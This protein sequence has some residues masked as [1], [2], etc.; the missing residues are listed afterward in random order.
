MVTFENP[1]EESE[2]SNEEKIGKLT[3]KLKDLYG[4]KLE[5]YIFI[6]GALDHDEE[7]KEMFFDE[8]HIPEDFSKRFIEQHEKEVEYSDVLKKMYESL[9]V[10]K[11]TAEAYQMVS[12]ALND[13]YVKERFE[14]DLYFPKRERNLFLHLEFLFNEDPSIL[15]HE[16]LPRLKGVKTKNMFNLLRFNIFDTNCEKSSKEDD[17]ENEDLFKEYLIFCEKCIEQLSRFGNMRENNGVFTF[18]KIED[19]KEILFQITIKLLIT[20]FDL[21][22][23]RYLDIEII[24]EELE[25][26]EIIENG[27]KLIEY[28]RRVKKP[29]P[30]IK[31][32]KELVEKLEKMVIFISLSDEINLISQIKDKKLVEHGKELISIIQEAHEESLI[33][34]FREAK[35]KIF[36][37]IENSESDKESDNLEEAQKDKDSDSDSENLDDYI[38]EHETVT[39][40]ED[41]EKAVESIKTIQEKIKS[42]KDAKGSKTDKVDKLIQDSK[43][44]EPYYYK[45]INKILYTL[46]FFRFNS[47]ILMKEFL[48]EC[49]RKNGYTSLRDD[50]FNSYKS[51]NETTVDIYLQKIFDELND[52]HQ[53]Q[54][55]GL[56]RFE[57]GFELSKQIN[58]ILL[59]LTSTTKELRVHHEV[60]E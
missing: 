23:S 27:H 18:E 19:G 25:L 38:V 52:I 17:E 44:G 42:I 9:S 1:F 34:H 5:N 56:K 43:R 31:D 24:K 58:S 55:A 45:Y 20:F 57:D 6:R 22:M 12:E 3:F 14:S 32:A 8:N 4:A 37:E 50:I 30:D 49:N 36:G 41:I 10:E 7:L 51:D 39:S 2:L 29:L 13:E 16:I 47:S 26:L 15:L 53:K 60:E 40:S 33:E 46:K 48:S 54:F 28:A 21:N 59:T 35:I 11:P